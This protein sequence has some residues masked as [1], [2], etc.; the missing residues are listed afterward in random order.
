MKYR[1]VQRAVGTAQGGRCT[2]GGSCVQPCSCA[3]V[4]PAPLRMLVRGNS[5]WVAQRGRDPPAVLGRG[6]PQPP[7]PLRGPQLGSGFWRHA[8]ACQVQ[9]PQQGQAH[10]QAQQPLPADAGAVLQ[11]AVWQ[12]N[13][14]GSTQAASAILVQDCPHHGATP[15]RGAFNLKTSKLTPSEG[16]FLPSLTS[17]TAG[18]VHWTPAGGRHCQTHGSR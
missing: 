16:S 6:N 11:A 4:W 3:W 12:T 17:A 5:C 7:T 14:S 18:W 10:S 1:N 15:P 2:M 13:N 8:A 9:L